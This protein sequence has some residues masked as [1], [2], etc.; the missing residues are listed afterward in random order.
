MNGGKFQDKVKHGQPVKLL[1]R[2]GSDSGYRRVKD[3]V[4]WAI[5]DCDLDTSMKRK[6]EF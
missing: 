5:R 2:R 4:A 3:P 1:A 6:F